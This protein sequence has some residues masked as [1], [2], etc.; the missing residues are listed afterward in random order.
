MRPKTAA[1]YEKIGLIKEV[2]YENIAVEVERL[3]ECAYK[4][5]GKSERDYRCTLLRSINGPII[6]NPRHLPTVTGA[7]KMNLLVHFEEGPASVPQVVITS[8]SEEPSG[9]GSGAWYPGHSTSEVTPVGVSSGVTRTVFVPR[10]KRKRPDIDQF[11]ES[12]KRR[13]VPR[14]LPTMQVTLSEYSVV[15][16]SWESFPPQTGRIVREEA[17]LGAGGYRN[18]YKGVLYLQNQ[19]PQSVVVKEFSQTGIENLEQNL[20]GELL[21]IAAEM[22][23]VI[24][25]NET[26]LEYAEMYND[27][28]GKQLIKYN[29]VHLGTLES[30]E[31]VFVEPFIEG[32]TWKAVLNTG[33]LET[34]TGLPEQDLLDLCLSFCHFT[35][36]QSDGKMIVLD[37]QGVN[38]TFIDPVVCTG[39]VADPDSALFDAGNMF[40]QAIINFKSWHLCNDRCRGLRLSSFPS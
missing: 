33:M 4:V 14:T 5:Y 6:E 15:D 17:L 7:G 10:P 29:K 38:N 13:P 1:K 2:E 30:G 27:R 12:G 36:E 40:E 32:E 35:L 18:A 22:K 37:I 23:I 16:C 34:G 19:Q 20:D 39:V 26:A 24:Q 21:D 11:L 28:A 9:S 8:D 31:T 3:R 25:T